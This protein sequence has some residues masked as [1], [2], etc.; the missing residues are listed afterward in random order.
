LEG[1]AEEAI[2]V[3]DLARAVHRGEEA[4]MIDSALFF[5]YCLAYY[6]VFSVGLEL[7]KIALVVPHASGV[8]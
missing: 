2:D 1:E 8:V 7:Y 6:L 4:A 5:C 3:R